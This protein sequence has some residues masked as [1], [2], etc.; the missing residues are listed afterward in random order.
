MNL[1]ALRAAIHY[2]PETGVFTRKVDAGT[3][4]RAGQECGCI[5]RADNST[6]GYVK[7]HVL[8]RKYKAHRLAWFYMTGR[9]PGPLDHINHDRADNRWA[10][11]REVEQADNAR[12]RAK[13][14]NNT[15]GFRGV[16]W[17]KPGRKWMAYIND[18]PRHRKNLG[19]FD[20]LLDAVA[21]RIGAE[22]E[23]GYHE[24]HG[25]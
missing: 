8:G 22:R 5:D 9:W 19:Y 14:R 1:D 7:V 12:N 4:W 24:N 18:R 16:I 2:D 21:T 17:Y 20:A 3:R 13:N 11:L 15:S 23:F 6:S 10:N 25:A